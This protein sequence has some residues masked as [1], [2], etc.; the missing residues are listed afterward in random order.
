MMAHKLSL[1]DL[2]AD[3]VLLSLCQSPNQNPE[4]V[5]EELD[6]EF[7]APAGYLDSAPK[8][9]LSRFDSSWKLPVALVSIPT[10]LKLAGPVFPTAADIKYQ[11]V[12][13]KLQPEATDSQ[14]DWLIDQLKPYADAQPWTIYDYRNTIKELSQGDQVMDYIFKSSTFVA[15][16]LCLFSLIA[17][18][19]TNIYEQSKEIAVLRALG[20]RARQIEKVYVYEAFVLTASAS[21]LGTSI[22]V[23]IGLNF[24]LFRFA[25]IIFLLS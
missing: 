18:M 6:I 15:M 12:L 14:K 20:L 10:L 25:M 19:Y 2:T 5:T 24:E 7:L 9:F 11:T 13:L 3:S 22:G 16:G 21:L 23:M 8:L 1:G 4:L 17:S